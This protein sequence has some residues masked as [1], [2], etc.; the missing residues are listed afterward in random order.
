MA[1]ATNNVYVF[2]SFYS[3][4]VTG[5]L[6]ILIVIL[7]ISNFKQILK[8]D[9]YKQISMLAVIAIAVGNHGLLHALF[10]PAK[11]TILLY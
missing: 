8:L 5:V 10:E 2:P 3:L 4:T 11:P 9:F 1:V 6:I 7:V